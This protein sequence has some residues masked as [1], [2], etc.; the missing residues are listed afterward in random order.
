MTTITNRD[1]QPSERAL[2]AARKLA[3]DAVKRDHWLSPCPEED[4]QDTET[5]ADLGEISQRHRDGWEQTDHFQLLYGKRLTELADAQE[6]RFGPMDWEER[7]Y[8]LY[9]PLKE[10]FWDEWEDKSGFW[11][12]AEKA[13]AER[14]TG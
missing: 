14:D 13:M 8:E 3:R 12:K 1:I 5:L 6:R 2:E 10:A 9:L 4:I 7:Y 11:E